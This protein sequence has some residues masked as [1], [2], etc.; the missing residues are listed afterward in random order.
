MMK[1]ITA[2]YFLFLFFCLLGAAIH[3]ADVPQKKINTDVFD[4]VISEITAKHYDGN[5]RQK[6]AQKINKPIIYI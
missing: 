2:K 1:E 5:F 4:A 3:G 6:Y